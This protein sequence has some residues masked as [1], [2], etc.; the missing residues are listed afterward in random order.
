MIRWS[1]QRLHG[2]RSGRAE[3]EPLLPGE[4]LQ[5]RAALRHPRRGLGEVGA[6]ARAHLGLGG[7][8][9]ADEMLVELG[10]RRRSLQLLEAVD[11]LERLGVEER[12]LLLDG[13]REVGAALEGFAGG[14]ELLL[15]GQS[16][17][18]AHATG[19]LRRARRRCG[20]G[21]PTTSASR[22]RG[23]RRPG[24]PRGRRRG[25]DSSSPS[26]APQVAGAPALERGEVPQ[27]LRILVLEPGRDLGEA[28]VA[29]DERRAAG[30]GSLGGDHPERLREDRR[31]DGGVRE[32]QQVHEVA[33]L[34]R[35]REERA[36][37]R[38][39]AS[40]RSR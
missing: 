31:N 11:E 26:F 28:G 8:Q 36:R 40:R 24:A 21:R 25:S 15:G 3:L 35:A 6:P 30:G 34:E 22:R 2:M 37:A 29:R 20:D 4:R 33:M 5:L 1:C 7:D 23:A 39:S 13:D 38:R 9:L 10:A 12:E 18:V 17:L 27:A 32:R 19:R 14:R 16:L